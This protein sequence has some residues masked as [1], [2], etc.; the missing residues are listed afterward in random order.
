MPNR[1]Y[2]INQAQHDDLAKIA[3][4]STRTTVANFRICMPLFDHI[5]LSLQPYPS[6]Y[7]AC[8]PVMVNSGL[9]WS[10][11][12]AEVVVRGKN[13]DLHCISD[14]A[15]LPK[16]A[17]R[18]PHEPAHFSQFLAIVQLKPS[19]L[20]S[21]LGGC[22]AMRVCNPT[23]NKTLLLCGDTLITLSFFLSTKFPSFR[24][25]LL[26]LSTVYCICCLPSCS[27]RR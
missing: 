3:N 6:I 1:I 5:W 7:H 16:Q 23:Y 4:V 26:H 24:F 20:W 25:A 2:D 18:L 21:I 14:S 10:H 17:V 11:T 8:H 9:I 27:H 12:S 15:K 22:H 13:E 19:F